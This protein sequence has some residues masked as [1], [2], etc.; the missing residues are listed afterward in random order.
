MAISYDNLWKLMIDKKMNKTDLQMKVHLS[1]STVTKL[2]KCKPV[3]LSVLE[4]ICKELNCDFGDI[5]SYQNE[6]RLIDE[7]EL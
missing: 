4:R 7:F 6:E 3:S 2:A 5:V 1:S